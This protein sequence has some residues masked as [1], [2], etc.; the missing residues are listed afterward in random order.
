MYNS[1]VELQGKN[2]FTALIMIS[3]QRY[4]T[5]HRLNIHIEPAVRRC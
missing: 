1:T 3:L 5:A 2:I 4:L